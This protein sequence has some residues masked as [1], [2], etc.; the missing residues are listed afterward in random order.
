MSQHIPK[1]IATRPFL[2]KRGWSDEQ[3]VVSIGAWRSGTSCASSTALG[4]RSPGPQ[5]V[6]Q[7][8]TLCSSV[9][10]FS[11]CQQRVL[12]HHEKIT[13]KIIFRHALER[14]PIS[15]HRAAASGRDSLRLVLVLLL[16][17]VG[18]PVGG[19]TTAWSPSR[20]HDGK[21]PFALARTLTARWTLAASR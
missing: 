14:G 11:V 19:K 1:C 3:P 4:S 10:Q 18:Q 17:D 6:Q 20:S 15:R 2:Q 8:Q 16:Q 7:I 9:W 21:T 12:R 13:D 5:R